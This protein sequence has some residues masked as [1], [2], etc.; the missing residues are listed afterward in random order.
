MSSDKIDSR[1]KAVLKSPASGCICIQSTAEY[2][3][4][5]VRYVSIA[6]TVSLSASLIFVEAV[7]LTIIH[8]LKPPTPT[9]LL[10]G[11]PGSDLSLIFINVT[12]TPPP[13]LPPLVPE[14][15]SEGGSEGG[16]AFDASG[17][18]EALP[19][20]LRELYG[21]A[22]VVV[23]LSRNRLVCYPHP[24]SLELLASIVLPCFLLTMT[25]FYAFKIRKTPSGF[26]EARAIGFVNYANCVLSLLTPV[27][28]YILNRTP[29][30]MLPLCILL[31]FSATS[32]LIGLLFPKLY[33]VLIHPEK[34]N[35]FKVMN[36]TRM[37][38]SPSQ[39]GSFPVATLM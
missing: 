20:E 13:I 37:G 7:V 27:L 2:G 14:D 6:S 19:M 39:L 4:K 25:T 24:F 10:A 31:L 3:A 9:Y 23:G 5:R 29:S 1:P 38:S 8:I 32:E 35:K 15:I 30:E 28:L 26:N 21:Q 12:P 33:V 22:E 17:A 18:S 16:S 34:N 36:K 11:Q